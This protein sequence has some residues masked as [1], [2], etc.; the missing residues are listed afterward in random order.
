MHELGFNS[1]RT[2][3]VR[4]RRSRYASRAG[5]VGAVVAV[6]LA[7]GLLHSSAAAAPTATASVAA[8]ASCDRAGQALSFA[9]DSQSYSP[10]I[11]TYDDP[12]VD[13]GN[14]P[15]FCAGEFVTNDDQA[16]HVGIHV[17]NRSALVA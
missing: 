5:T 15:D 7:P 17:H 16:I 9:S 1:V 10:A 13:S 12:I 4:R 14:A 2:Q 6:V 11:R 8:T 3:E